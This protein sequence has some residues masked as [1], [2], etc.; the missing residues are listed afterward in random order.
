VIANE[1]TVK[2]YVRRFG[3]VHVRDE[4]VV[5]RRQQNLGF[6]RK[7]NELS[8]RKDERCTAPIS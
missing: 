2:V 7:D 8:G 6:D 4:A 1:L 3:S 5:G